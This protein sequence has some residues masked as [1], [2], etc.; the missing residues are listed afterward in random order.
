MLGY[1]AGQVTGTAGVPRP[2]S[3][4]GART[5]LVCGACGITAVTA[6]LT[7]TRTIDATAVPTM[8]V[9]GFSASLTIVCQAALSSM[10]M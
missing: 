4:R 2:I 7:A 3:R 6:I 1:G 10:A 5:A 9:L 8:A